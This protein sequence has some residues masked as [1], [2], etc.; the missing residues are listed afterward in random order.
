[1]GKTLLAT[2]L[3]SPA[4]EGKEKKAEEPQT[5]A[6]NIA[7]VVEEVKGKGEEIAEKVKDVIIGSED[8]VKDVEEAKPKEVESTVAKPMDTIVD[9]G[10]ATIAANCRCWTPFA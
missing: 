6:E 8:T 3:A 7:E 5:V 9:Q 1:M 2:E 10:S 4:R